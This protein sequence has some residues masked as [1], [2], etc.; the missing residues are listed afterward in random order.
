MSLLAELGRVRG[1]DLSEVP[2]PSDAR[3]CP[4]CA[5]FVGAGYNTASA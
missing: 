3:E 4:V 1:G 5:K 2:Q